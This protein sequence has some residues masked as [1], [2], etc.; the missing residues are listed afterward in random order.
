MTLSNV[1][2]KPTRLSYK[3]KPALERIR[4]AQ[5]MPLAAMTITLVRSLNTDT[6]DNPSR[7]GYQS[8]PLLIIPIKL[9]I[10]TAA[11]P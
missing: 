4:I 9:R 2:A 11:R 6:H 7:G 5:P 1:N 10:M 8:A 3:L